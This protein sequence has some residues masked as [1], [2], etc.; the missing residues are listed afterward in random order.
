MSKLPFCSVSEQI[1]SIRFW[2]NITN[3]LYWSW[4]RWR[5]CSLLKFEI[6]DCL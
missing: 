2:W 3:S 5:H 4:A 6:S 1:V